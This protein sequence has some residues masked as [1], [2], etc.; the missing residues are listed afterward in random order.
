MRRKWLGASVLLAA[1]TA[2]WA[3]ARVDAVRRVVLPAPPAAEAQLER[4]V[5]ELRIEGATFEQA[6]EILR[7]RTGAKITVDRQAIESGHD[8]LPA[9]L[10]RPLD[11]HVRDMTLEQVLGRLCKAA[12]DGALAYTADG[13]QIV[14]TTPAGLARYTCVR[15]YDIRDILPPP[16]TP[17]RRSYLSGNG[18]FGGQ[19]QQL[20]QL[21]GSTRFG[22]Q[23][24]QAP[25]LGREDVLQDLIDAITN[26]IATDG[27]VDNGGT[28][29]SI[30]E[31]G[32]RLIIRQTPANHRE[33]ARLLDG[34]RWAMRPPA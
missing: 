10:A 21:Q 1:V 14:V 12:D 4:P 34:L 15:V 5:G 18:L 8:D 26:L 28:I 27:W 7:Q 31:V 16:G 30:R 13:D 2:A 25:A 6:L 23:Q 29:G 32:G 24:Q 17:R 19:Q 11:L 33:I 9:A 3:V 22:N 20:Q